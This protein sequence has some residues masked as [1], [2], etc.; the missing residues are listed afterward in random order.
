M[1]RLAIN[2][3]LVATVRRDRSVAV[4]EVDLRDAWR[5]TRTSDAASRLDDVRSKLLVG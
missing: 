1:V 5:R 2:G 4:S 3:T